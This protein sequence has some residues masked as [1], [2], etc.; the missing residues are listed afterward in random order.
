MNR[1]MLYPRTEQFSIASRAQDSL[2][3]QFTVEQFLQTQVY[4]GD[5]FTAAFSACTTACLYLSAVVHPQITESMMAHTGFPM[6]KKKEKILLHC[7]EVGS[8]GAKDPTHSLNRL[9][10]CT[11]L[12][13]KITAPGN[14]WIIA[15][16]NSS[17]KKACQVGIP[18]KLND[19]AVLLGTVNSM[20]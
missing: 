4:N 3:L 5:S 17:R 7:S 20:S 12:K 11:R 9:N 13:T 14:L 2:F 15:F 18:P 8:S 1:L 6:Q 10:C 16:N 19:K